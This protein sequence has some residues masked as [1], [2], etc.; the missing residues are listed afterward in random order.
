MKNF[1]ADEKLKFP[2]AYGLRRVL[3]P[4]LI[5]VYLL[6]A[7][8]APV[9]PPAEKVLVLLPSIVADPAFDVARL[10][11]A[12]EL[13]F[14]NG[15]A[16]FQTWDLST[17]D[18][19]TLKATGT[20]ARASF[21]VALTW[22]PSD[23]GWQVEQQ[24]LDIS[25]VSPEPRARSLAYR[26]LRDAEVYRAIAL[27]LSSA[28]R[29][30]RLSRAA[31]PKVVEAP[32][33]P[34]TPPTVSALP[35]PTPPAPESRSAAFELA[36]STGLLPAELGPYAQAVFT[37]PHTGPWSVGIG[38]EYGFAVPAVPKDAGQFRASLA[39]T[40]TLPFS[41]GR[42]GFSAR[43]TLGAIAV[44]G[45]TQPTAGESVN[46]V[47]LLPCATLGL[48]AARELTAGLELLLGASADAV[49]GRQQLGSS[50][51]AAFATNWL[52]PRL[53]LGL[54]FTL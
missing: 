33:A 46:R 52:I 50:S 51:Q 10:R 15:T 34:P 9:P 13:Y 47:T 43:G 6:G 23:L 40:R 8:T 37:L 24:L 42:F 36:A 3:S 22:H 44:Y 26:E 45:A 32:T 48:L 20:A 38:L 21:V 35:A 16:L 7:D 19:S 49:F 25:A 29:S 31:T 18:P 4:L 54:R 1:I 2:L 39:L 41:L 12:I 11:S 30:A 53:Q 5:T 27:R 14:S 17:E 28:V